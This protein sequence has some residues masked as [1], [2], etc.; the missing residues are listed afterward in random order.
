MSKR[1]GW[2][3]ALVAITLYSTNNPIGRGAILAGMHP[4]TL[5]LGRF[6]LASLLFV[7]TLAFTSL[8]QPRGNQ[9]RLDRFGLAASVISGVLNGLMMAMIFWAL[10]RV[11]ASI[12]SMIT[13]S[14]SPVF[15]LGLLALAGE[16]FTRRNALRLGLALA[17]V[18]LLVGLGGSVDPWGVGLLVAGAAL[19]ALHIVS[20]QWFL[21]GYNTWQVATLIVASASAV[22]VMLWWASDATWYVPGWGGWLAIG[23]QGL[24]T[25]W[26]GRFLTYSAINRIGSGQFALLTPLEMMLSI[27]WAVLFLSEAL[28]GMQWLGA[29]L[30]LMSTVLAGSWS[31][32]GRLG[33]LTTKRETADTRG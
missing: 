16:R 21:R 12:T 18:Y 7:A 26:I 24:L 10:A 9:R 32:R 29:V 27:W 11:S 31:L 2:L 4:L 15:A 6:L 17:G 3:F 22:I 14:L 1:S 20:V 8:G 23:V 25:T 5:L 19:Y 33:A 13:I 30:I 28:A